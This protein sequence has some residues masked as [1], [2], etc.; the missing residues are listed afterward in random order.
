MSNR[1]VVMLANSTHPPTDT[2]I[3]QK[4]AKTLVAAGY[5]VTLIVPHTESFVREGITVIAV[6]LRKKVFAMPTTQV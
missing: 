5:T 4:E 2:R 1:T 6:P 3:F